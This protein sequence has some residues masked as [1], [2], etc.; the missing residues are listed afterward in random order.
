MR[1]R[2]HASP[3]VL[4]V[5]FAR[6][7]ASDPFGPTGEY[8]GGARVLVHS[9]LQATSRT[10]RRRASVACREFVA[11]GGGGGA[12]AGACRDDPALA[13][14]YDRARNRMTL[15]AP[16]AAAV[17]LSQELCHA[18]PAAGAAVLARRAPGGAA[19]DAQHL[20]GLG[21]DRRLL[22]RGRLRLAAP[23]RVLEH[24]RRRVRLLG[25]AVPLRGRDV[26]ARLPRA[27]DAR[28]GRAQLR[29][30]PR[31]RD[32]PLRTR[33]KNHPQY[34][35]VGQL[36][37]YPRRACGQNPIAPGPCIDDPKHL[38]GARAYL[39]RPTHDRC[40]L[41][42]LGREHGLAATSTACSCTTPRA[43][44]SS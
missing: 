33:C 16:G 32:A 13:L 28:V 20:G 43:R 38:Y 29:R 4:A 30:L 37:D 9:E 22:A 39:F 14:A 26:R 10:S 25:P 8:C 21:R 27:A 7:S 18:L 6:A 36:V 41:A 15:S 11:P 12:L 17:E 34:V 42:A 44:S 24:G 35:D 5:L 2:P 19:A 3:L 23:H 40:Y 31:E 1:P